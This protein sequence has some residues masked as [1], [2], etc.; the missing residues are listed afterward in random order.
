MKF[1]DLF[2]K[3]IKSSLIKNKFEIKKSVR[4]LKMKEKK[5]RKIKRSKNE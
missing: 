4:V 5:T 1:Y 3:K 2:C